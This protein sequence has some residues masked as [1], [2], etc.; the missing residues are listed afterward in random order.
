MVKK[1]NL[2]FVSLAFGSPAEEFQGIERG[3]WSSNTPKWVN[4]LN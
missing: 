3:V 1:T 2:H 4:L